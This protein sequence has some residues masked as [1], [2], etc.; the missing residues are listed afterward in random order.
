VH[1]LS[2]FGVRMSHEQPQIHKS[3]HNLN[4]GEATTFSLIVYFV[5]LHGATSKWHFVSGLLNGKFPELGLPQLWGPIT[6]CE[7]LRLQWGLKQSCSPCWK[8]SNGMLHTTC[9][10]GNWVNSWLLVFKIKL[11]IWLP[12]FLLAITC[13]SNVQMVHAN[14]FQ[15]SMFK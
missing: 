9:T 1:S 5:P 11:P 8:L 13:V 14:P 10:Q 15:T 4:L 12:T 7:N 6:L 2:I 3:H